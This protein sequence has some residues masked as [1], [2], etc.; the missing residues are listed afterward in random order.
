MKTKG[1]WHRRLAQ[2]NPREV[3][4]AEQW[5][6][7][8]DEGQVLNT[9]LD[10]SYAEKVFSPFGP[11]PAS[12]RDHEV[13]ATVIQW[14]GSNVGMDFLRQVIQKSPE[15]QRWFKVLPLLLACLSLAPVT[16]KGAQDLVDLAKRPASAGKTLPLAPGRPASIIRSLYS[17]DFARSFTLRTNYPAPSPVAGPQEA[18]VVKAVPISRATQPPPTN[19]PIVLPQFLYTNIPPNYWWHRLEADT[20]SDAQAGRWRTN[21]RNMTMPPSGTVR[22]VRTNKAGYWQMMGTPN[23]IP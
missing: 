22:L 21:D 16:R 5:D 12:E 20:L 11:K 14:L 17:A 23:Q 9:L 1:I 4:F 18:P 13:A 6:R 10:Q 8:N 19:G 2:D 7:E 15:I 3:V